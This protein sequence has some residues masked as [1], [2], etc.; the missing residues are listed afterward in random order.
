MITK[1]SSAFYR[2]NAKLV[3]T[4]FMH[5]AAQKKPKRARLGFYSFI[6]HS[7]PNSNVLNPSIRIL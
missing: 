6:Y 5:V 2:N 3:F 1:V 7:A 4:D